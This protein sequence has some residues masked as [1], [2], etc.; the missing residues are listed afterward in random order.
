MQ[1]FTLTSLT[2][3]L[4]TPIIKAAQTDLPLLIRGPTGSGKEHLARRL[5]ASSA[6]PGKFIAVN[7]ATLGHGLS[8]AELFGSM[9][10]SYTGSERDRIGLFEAAD[11]GTI[12]LDEIGDTP[13]Q[14]QAELLRVLET[15]TV[16]R[17]GTHTA[18]PVN[19]RVISA[20]H[21]PLENRIEHGDF[22]A[23]L[24]Y[25]LQGLEIELPA[26]KDAP[27]DIIALARSI[28]R[29]H[30][31]T[32]E[33][34]PEA[35]E[36]MLQHPW[37]GNVRELK[38]SL[39]R[40]LALCEGPTLDESF[41]TWKGASGDATK[42]LGYKTHLI[43]DTLRYHNGSLTETAKSLGLHRSTIHRHVTK[44]R[45]AQAITTL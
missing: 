44:L 43:A 4:P 2:Q 33:L 26:L 39:L 45:A 36:A 29:A 3:P 42:A 10:G 8:Q 30:S 17:L 7:M 21:Q 20:T 18:K 23:D 35:K 27:G 32:R 31:E 1:N 12:F 28:L 22:R 5:H 13:L 41:F 11:H 25:R 38:Q 16:R 37:P 24:Y 34:S 15:K 6:R 14:T 19:F 9:K 40:A